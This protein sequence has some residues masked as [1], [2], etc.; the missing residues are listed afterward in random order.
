MVDYQAVQAVNSSVTGATLSLVGAPVLIDIVIIIDECLS[1]KKVNVVVR[2]ALGSIVFELNILKT[3][4]DQLLQT[5]APMVS[6]ASFRSIAVDKLIVETEQV[7]Y[8]M[9][10]EAFIPPA[11]SLSERSNDRPSHF[12]KSIRNHRT[13]N[14]ATSENQNE[15]IGQSSR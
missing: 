6:N 14:L 2:D 3:I 15:T 8:I 10:Q 4:A 1:Q 7:E 5:E 12:R 13:I 11:P 9:K